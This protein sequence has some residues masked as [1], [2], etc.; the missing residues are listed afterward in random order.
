MRKIPNKNIKKQKQTTTTTTKTKLIKRD[1][2]GR[3]I[4]THPKK[5]LPR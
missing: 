5:I 4:D 2:E 3:T 1:R